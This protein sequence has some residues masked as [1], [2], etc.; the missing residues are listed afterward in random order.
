MLRPLNPSV[1]SVIYGSLT[2]L[3]ISWQF[4]IAWQASLR[5]VRRFFFPISKDCQSFTIC[6]VSVLHMRHI[7]DATPA[8]VHILMQ[9]KLQSV[10]CLYLQIW[11]HPLRLP[12]STSI[13]EYFS[14][15]QENTKKPDSILTLQRSFMRRTASLRSL[16]PHCMHILQS[17]ILIYL[18]LTARA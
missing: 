11:I 16:P 3:L 4:P 13:M 1:K 9:W 10:P 5:T 2:I 6:T 15:K 7:S 18:R 14:V 8:W 12:Y 17:V